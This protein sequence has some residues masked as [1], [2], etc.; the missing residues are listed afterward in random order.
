MHVNYEPKLI[1]GLFPPS[2]NMYTDFAR[3]PK[4]NKI[5]ALYIDVVVLYI[6]VML[7]LY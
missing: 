4:N 2:T 7:L 5:V 6:D 1:L 3:N